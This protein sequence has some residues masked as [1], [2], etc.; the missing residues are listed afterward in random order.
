MSLQAGVVFVRYEIL[1]RVRYLHSMIV[2][3]FLVTMRD[4]QLF[5][6]YTCQSNSSWCILSLFC[7]FLVAARINS[8]NVSTSICLLHSGHW[9]RAKCRCQSDFLLASCT[10]TTAT[11][12]RQC[13]E[14]CTCTLCRWFCCTRTQPALLNDCYS[15]F[16]LDTLKANPEHLVH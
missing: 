6:K 13:N 10:C 3:W 11:G 12:E 16:I 14:P 9:Q 7:N 2:V 8:W 15:W 4:C 5:W 1:W